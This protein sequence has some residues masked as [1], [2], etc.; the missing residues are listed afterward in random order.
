MNAIELDRKTRSKMSILG[1]Y[2][3]NVMYNHLYISAKD[4]VK[5]GDKSTSLTDELRAAVASYVTGVTTNTKY[6][7]KTIKELHQWWQIHTNDNTI[8]LTE[9]QETIVSTFVPN[10]Y[11][12]NLNN[13]QKDQFMMKIIY[14]AVRVFAG[15]FIKPTNLF[16]TI[17]D[18]INENNPKVLT[19]IIINILSNEREKIHYS[20]TKQ[21]TGK[22]GS[23]DMEL[24][25]NLKSQLKKSVMAKCKLET[26]IEKYKKDKEELADEV[27]RLKARNEKLYK[28]L[29]DAESRG[30]SNNASS[31]QSSNYDQ[32]S[33]ESA[34]STNED[35][36]DDT[37]NTNETSG[38]T[39]DVSDD[40]SEEMT[41]EM[42]KAQER[43]QARRKAR[44]N[45]SEAY[46]E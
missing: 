22:T 38:D 15:E 3:V 10:E 34:N 31:Y 29:L 40:S 35:V 41:E 28:E 5:S 43:R 8:S 2:F 26:T 23:I 11:I 33:N 25:E 46:M 17:D 9:F 37:V 7:I 16:R 14:A 27:K 6:Y 39:S 36:T 4:R 32:G 18:H 42:K 13:K 24:I 12:N 1:T 30:G 19:D 44:F 20:F 45:T 21:I